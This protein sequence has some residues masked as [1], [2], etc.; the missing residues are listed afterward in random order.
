MSRTAA[1]ALDLLAEVAA[2][3]E[4]AGLL[5]LA[6]AV[7]LDKSTAARL[8]AFLADRDLVVR[9]PDTRRYGPGPALVALSAGVLQ[10]SSLR[11]IARPHLE[12]LRDLTG[13]TV[14][15]HLLV[16]GSV[17]CIDGAE[18][19]HAIRRA[20]PLGESLPLGA[21]VTSK[22]VLAQLPRDEIAAELGGTPTAHLHAQLAAA[23]ADGWLAGVGDR[24]PGV[25][26]LAASIVPIGGPIGALT[27]AGPGERWTEDRMSEHAPALR[28]AVASIAEALEAATA[29]A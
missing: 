26:A 7:S 15:L 3:P 23:R 22:V 17:V 9:D 6:A 8:L 5:D 18:S 13:E 2:R 1:R 16:D 24:I 4:P 29:T 25:S 10:R 20:I 19:R 14:T 11:S 27:I 12:R 28:D 21:G